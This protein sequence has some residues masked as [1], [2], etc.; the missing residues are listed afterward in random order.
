MREKVELKQQELMELA[1][2]KGV[3]DDSVLDKQLILVRS[4]LFREYAVLLIKSKPGSQ[5]AGVDKMIYDKESEVIFDELVEYLRDMTYHPNKY[6]SANI[7]R[8]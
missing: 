5:T 2:L 3:Y 8:V 4:R 6:K 1:K 7:R